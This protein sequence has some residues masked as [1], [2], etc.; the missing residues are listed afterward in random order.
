LQFQLWCSEIPQ[1][2]KVD[3]ILDGYIMNLQQHSDFYAFLFEIWY[4]SG[5]SKKIRNAFEICIEKAASV[6]EYYWMMRGKT[7]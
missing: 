1:K 7:A 6:I 3:D 4:A 2:E 5:R